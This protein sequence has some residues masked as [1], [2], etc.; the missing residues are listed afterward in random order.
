MVIWKICEVRNYVVL[1]AVCIQVLPFFTFTVICSH[2]SLQC[3]SHAN[4]STDK[5]THTLTGAL[6]IVALC[7][8]S[9]ASCQGDTPSQG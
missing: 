5:F 6:D 9:L 3:D 1:E 8:A 4:T 2:V 7:L